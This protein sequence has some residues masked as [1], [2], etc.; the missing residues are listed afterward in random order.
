MDKEGTSVR[1]GSRERQV[2]NLNLKRILT[3]RDIIF[4]ALASKN[5]I[6]RNGVGEKQRMVFWWHEFSLARKHHPGTRRER[7]F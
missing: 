7:H 2:K 5:G 6:A 1:Q 3:N 4:L